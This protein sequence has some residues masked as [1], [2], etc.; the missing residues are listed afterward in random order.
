[1]KGQRPIG[2]A[3]PFFD[4]YLMRNWLNPLPA[5]TVVGAVVGAVLG[6]ILGRHDYLNPPNWLHSLFA[7]QLMFLILAFGICAHFYCA[8]HYLRKPSIAK[9]S[10]SGCILTT[11]LVLF[12]YPK[13]FGIGD[14]ASIVFLPHE[15]NVL[16]AGLLLLWVA[17]LRLL[18]EFKRMLRE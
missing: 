10:L 13:H 11:G 18:T 3:I 17:T 4:G 2:N 5:E 12:M 1:L 14:D 15:F 6:S 16:M 9:W 7:F 8:A